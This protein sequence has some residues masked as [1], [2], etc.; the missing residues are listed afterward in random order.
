[1]KRLFFK[2]FLWFWLGMIVMSAALVTSAALTQSRSAED[3]RWRQKYE[4]PLQM[5]SRHEA[6]LIENHE[7]PDA[8]Q[9]IDSLE[10]REPIGNFMLDDSGHEVL[11][12]K[13]PASVLSVLPQLDRIPPAV[14][15]FLSNDRIMAEKVVGPSGR[16]YKFFMKFPPRPFFPHSLALFFFEDV[17]SEGI[18]RLVVLLVTATVFCLWLARHITGPIGKLRWAASQIANQNLNTR[19]DVGVT[20]RHDEL[21][22]L[23]RD[24]NRMAKRIGA[25]VGAQRRLLADVS[26]ELRS[27]LTRLNLALGL[28]RQHAS[29]K[30]LEHLD[31]MERETERLNNLIGQLLSLARIESG[32]DL[33]ES[34]PFELGALVQEV[35]SDGDYEARSRNCRVKFDQSPDCYVEGTREMLRGAVENVVR[36]AVRHTGNDSTVEV[37]IERQPNGDGAYAVIRIRDHGS[38]VPESELADLFVPFHRVADGIRNDPYGTGLGLAIAERTFRLH[39]GSVSA[40]NAVDGGLIVT[41]QLPAFKTETGTP[42]PPK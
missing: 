23:G 30:N 6:D 21:A 41:L 3:Q 10:Q 36:N 13:V 33:Q 15:L 31:R 26:H 35:A 4:L 20:G 27:P 5:R 37:S 42:I 24:F 32:V 22:D 29:P 34:K 11:G 1:M 40:A 16:Q 12:R 7:I 25:L 17:G 14:P 19:V 28:A 2:I 9:Y 39:G 8:A 18:I 38:G